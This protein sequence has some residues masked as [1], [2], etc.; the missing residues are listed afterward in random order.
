M[1]SAEFFAA[2]RALKSGQV[3]AYPTETFYGLGADPWNDRAVDL[4]LEL[5][6]RPLAQGLPLILAKGNILEA[7][8]GEE[9]EAVREKRRRLQ[10]VFWPG[11][12]TLVIS[13]SDAA[14]ARFAQGVLGPDGSLAVRFSSN[15]TA[16]E[17]A[18]LAGGAITATSANPKALPPANSAKEAK[19]Y[20]PGLC[21]VRDNEADAAS[22]SADKKPSTLIDVRSLPFCLLR[23][24]AVGN[25]ELSDYLS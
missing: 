1:S 9:S 20:Y 10:S 11:P 19:E 22:P 15:Q 7:W 4:L 16:V 3:I 21:I 13:L 17:L 2:E 8:I 12:L 24:G 25:E 18:K 23:E 5:K 14:K 6:S